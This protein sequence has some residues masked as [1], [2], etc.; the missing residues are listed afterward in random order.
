MKAKKVVNF[1]SP[2]LKS[3]VL[4]CAF[5]VQQSAS[6]NLAHAFNVPA[7]SPP[8]QVDKIAEEVKKINSLEDAVAEKVKTEKTIEFYTSALR[9]LLRDMESQ[10]P[11]ELAANEQ[12]LKNII[13]EQR[14]KLKLLDARIVELEAIQKIFEE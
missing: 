9:Q 8:S 5:L 12:S 4:V 2:N 10:S 13:Q 3:I 6:T 1:K 7:S 11:R 14:R